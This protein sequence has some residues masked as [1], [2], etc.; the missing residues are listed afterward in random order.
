MRS[1][2]IQ[3]SNDL[4]TSRNQAGRGSEICDWFEV[5]PSYRQRHRAISRNVQFLYATVLQRHLGT[6]QPMQIDLNLPRPGEDRIWNTRFLPALARIFESQ[7]LESLH[8][9]RLHTNTNMDYQHACRFWGVSERKS[10]RPS[11]SVTRI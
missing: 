4:P 8:K 2:R 1:L 6:L 9:F 10:I 3:N 5:L 7:S 11:L